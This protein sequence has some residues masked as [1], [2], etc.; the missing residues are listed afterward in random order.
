MG[1]PDIMMTFWLVWIGFGL[2]FIGSLPFGML[3]LTVADLGMR[4]GM[5]PA[6]LFAAGAALLEYGQSLIAI[7]FAQWFIAGSTLRTYID[8][9]AV[10]I[11]FSLGLYFLL[12]KSQPVKANQE[13][14]QADHH[15]FMKG[16][17]MAVFNVIVYPYWVFYSTFLINQGWM[18]TSWADSLAFSAGITLG[19]WALFYG[20]ARFSVWLI[21]RS[22]HFAKYA[23]RFFALMVFTLG[24]IQLYHNLWG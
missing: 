8:W 19:A 11:F 2:S 15:Y 3:N 12:S 1:K 24:A 16:V 23:T 6:L 5:R 22:E 9:A 14:P 10:I 20:Y 13:L 17:G 18:S 21:G 4:K 7:R